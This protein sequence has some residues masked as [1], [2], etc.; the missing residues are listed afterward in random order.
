MIVQN[1]PSAGS[2]FLRQQ[3]SYRNQTAHGSSR[4]NLDCKGFVHQ[5]YL[6]T[7]WPTIACL[8]SYT[9]ALQP[10]PTVAPPLACVILHLNSIK[11]TAYQASHIHERI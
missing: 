6:G 11:Q 1:C 4:E 2:Q 8:I 3:H 10:V 9:A 7:P 5:P